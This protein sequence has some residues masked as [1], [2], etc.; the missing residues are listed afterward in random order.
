MSSKIL[1]YGVSSHLG[2]A[3][4]SLLDFLKYYQKSK[5]PKPFYV[6]LPKNE[7]PLIDELKS[8]KIEYAT[9]AF[10]YFWLRLSRQSINSQLMFLFFGLPGY[11]IYL[12]RLYWHLKHQPLS[13]IHSTGIK[14]HISLCL[15]HYFL[16]AQIIIHFRDL[17]SSHL[18][19][20]IF[21]SFNKSPKI[22]WITASAAISKTF[23]Q[24][25]TE[26]IYCGFSETQYAPNK[27]HY[28]HDLLKL[29]YQHKLIGLVG[30]F[31]RWK[32]QKEFI[33]AANIALR[34]LKDHH[35]LLI[36]GQIYDT[37]G[38]VGYTQ[39]LHDLVSALRQEEYIHFVPFQKHPEVVYNSLDLIVHCSIEPEPF[40][41]VIVEGLFC[42]VPM[43]ASAAGGALEIIKDENYGLLHSPGDYE[44]LAQQMIKSLKDPDRH[45]KALL[46]AQKARLDY[47]LD[48][49]FS[50]LKNI[51][52]RY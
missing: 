20:K 30:V 25:P 22:T 39:S 42:E 44:T 49:R 19:Q 14:C 29:P 8:N 43:I 24:L 4:R 37:S 40:G 31:A 13:A 10:P 45:Q 35:F 23:P 2:G 41:R 36:G 18:L 28:L 27:N 15:L 32:G 5:D 9:L 16:S 17:M 34:E 47:G 52:E 26:V 38:E 33:L 50:L 11:F 12:C 3:E 1:F 46:A 21:M 7:G 51:I 6:L 48:R